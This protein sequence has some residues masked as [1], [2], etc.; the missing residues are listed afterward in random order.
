VAKALIKVDVR[1]RASLLEAL[2]A[3]QEFRQGHGEVGF[4]LCVDNNKRHIGYVILEWASL[5]SLNEFLE[6]AHVQ[7]TVAS[8]PVVEVLEVLELYDLEKDMNA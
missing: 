7:E 4:S 3:Q 5:K 8:W 6:S 2:R 1:K